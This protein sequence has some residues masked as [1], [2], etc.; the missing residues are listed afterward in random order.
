M[1]VFFGI[2]YFLVGIVQLFAI[3]EGIKYASGLGS[4]FSAFMALI[5]TYI[6]VV[7]SIAGVYGAVNVWDWSIWQAGALFF[8]YLPV[9][10]VILVFSHFFNR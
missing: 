8:W 7:G 1:Q 5:I 4:F 9:G 6:P 10:A 3:I 2:A